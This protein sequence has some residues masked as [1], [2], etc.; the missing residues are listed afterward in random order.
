MRNLRHDLILGQARTSGS[1]KLPDFLCPV[2]LS[3]F[4]LLKRRLVFYILRVCISSTKSD[5]LFY[6]S[7][8]MW[9]SQKLLAHLCTDVKPT[10]SSGRLCLKQANLSPDSRYMLFGWAPFF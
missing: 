3:Y 8:T 7:A 6:Y 4:A 2:G 9:S 10:V 5:D 1:P